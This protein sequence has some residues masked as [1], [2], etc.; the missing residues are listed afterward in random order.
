M[1]VSVDVDVSS[2]LVRA[3][4]AAVMLGVSAGRVRQLIGSGALAGEKQS[5]DNYVHLWSIRERLGA[6][7]AA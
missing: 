3:C 6:H 5:R 1:Y 2:Q 4:D 7:S